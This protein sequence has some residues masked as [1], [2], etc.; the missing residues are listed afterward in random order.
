MQIKYSPHTGPIN[1]I[2]CF[3]SLFNAHLTRRPRPTKFHAYETGKGQYPRVSSGTPT[4]SPPSADEEEIK[5]GCDRQGLTEARNRSFWPAG[6][7]YS[8]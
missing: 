5:K 2:G 4:T 8:N 7:K 6:T 3:S 1:N